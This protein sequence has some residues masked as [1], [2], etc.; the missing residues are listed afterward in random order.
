MDPEFLKALE[1]VAE[2]DRQRPIVVIEHRL[3]YADDGSIIG[4]SESNHPSDTNYIVLANMDV[5]NKN[6]TA[7]LKVVSGKLTIVDLTQPLKNGI[8][9]SL[10]GQPVVKGHAALALNVD[11]QYSN[12]EYYDRK[13]NH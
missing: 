6:N 4:L 1:L 9:K 7:T 10:S 5:F 8:E 12:I 13:T 3:Y 11:E 2:Y